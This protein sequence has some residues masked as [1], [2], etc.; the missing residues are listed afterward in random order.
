MLVEA[1]VVCHKS[2][3]KLSFTSQNS[4]MLALSRQCFGTLHVHSDL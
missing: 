1:E 3:M 4:K 2:N